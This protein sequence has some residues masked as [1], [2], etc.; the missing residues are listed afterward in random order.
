MDR[1]HVV[2]VMLV[3]AELATEVKMTRPAR[4]PNIQLFIDMELI[5][6]EFLNMNRARAN[7]SQVRFTFAIGVEFYTGNI[8]ALRLRVRCAFPDRSNL[9]VGRKKMTQS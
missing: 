5:D 6:I 1:Y 9:Q 2:V 4:L 7:F 8:V 3:A